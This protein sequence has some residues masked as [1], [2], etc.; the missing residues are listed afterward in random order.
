QAQELA[1]QIQPPMAMPSDPNKMAAVE[2]K[3]QGDQLRAQ[4]ERE[5]IAAKE[6]EREQAA[7]QEREKVFA[8]LS[9]EQQREELRQAE[10]SARQAREHAA[11]LRELARKE[12]AEDRRSAADREADERQNTQDN[13][14]ALRIAH[15][16]IESSERVGFSTGK[17]I[18]Q[19]PSGGRKR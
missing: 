1:A 12:A 2:A 4:I 19:N 5:K 16:E 3:K 14:T 11:R 13:V 15:A 9:A 18:D 10:E 17:G 7:Q 8:T 6:R